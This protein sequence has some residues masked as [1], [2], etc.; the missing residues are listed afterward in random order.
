MNNFNL[1]FGIYTFKKVFQMQ[2]YI[3]VILHF[4]YASKCSSQK[5]VLHEIKKNKEIK[6]YA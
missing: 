1:S 6:L 2:S 3:L 5:L 4:P